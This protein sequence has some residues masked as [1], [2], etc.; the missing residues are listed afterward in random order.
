MEEWM[1]SLQWNIV[2]CLSWFGAAFVLVVFMMLPELMGS[3]MLKSTVIHQ[4][5]PSGAGF[6]FHHDKDL[7][8]TA[9]AVKSYLERK[10]ADKTLTVIDWP[11]QSP[12]LNT[13]EVVWDQLD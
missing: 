7:K 11:L 4:G 3:W 6:I 9:N 10:T 5:I 12:G 8:H 2:E 13:I 1:C